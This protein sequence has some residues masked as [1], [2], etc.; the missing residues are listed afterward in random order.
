MSVCVPIDNLQEANNFFNLVNT[1]GEVFVT[2][3][4]RS[5]IR[6]VCDDDTEVSEKEAHLRLQSRMGIA[7][8]EL[9]EEKF[10][11]LDNVLNN[12]R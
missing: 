7:K 3:N 11:L 6:C 2:R 8:K 9:E 12:L 1:E 4:G 10:Q 5:F